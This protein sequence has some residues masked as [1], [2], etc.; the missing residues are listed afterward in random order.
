M[1]R[2]NHR[3]LHDVSCHCVERGR[4]AGLHRRAGRHSC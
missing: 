4:H 1:K 2:L 3:P